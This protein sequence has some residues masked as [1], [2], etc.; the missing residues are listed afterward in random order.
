MLASHP[1]EPVVLLGVLST[2]STLQGVLQGREQPDDT[3][4]LT[5]AILP[6][7]KGLAGFTGE[8]CH[9]WKRRHDWLLV[10]YITRR[11]YE[12]RRE[13]HSRLGGG[14]GQGLEV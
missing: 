6:G 8:N 3:E 12:G 4:Y 5:T 7:K 9:S 2:C 13:R 1:P 14:T 11:Q 10:Y